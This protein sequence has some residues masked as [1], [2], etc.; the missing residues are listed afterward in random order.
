MWFSL[1]KGFGKG[2]KEVATWGLQAEEG[3]LPLPLASVSRGICM[4]EQKGQSAGSHVPS[5]LGKK[6]TAILLSHFLFSSALMENV[7]VGGRVENSPEFIMH[8]VSG[9]RRGR[10]IRRLEF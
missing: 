6:N 3:A 7:E 8:L 1:P 2:L 10:R 9:K 5:M 4:H